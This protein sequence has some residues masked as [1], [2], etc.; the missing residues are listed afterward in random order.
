MTASRSA[1]TAGRR[2]RLEPTCLLYAGAQST[3][4]SAAGYRSRAPRAEPSEPGPQAAAAP[5]P[6][7]GKEPHGGIACSGPQGQ[8]GAPGAGPGGEGREGGANAREGGA[9]RRAGRDRGT[10][11]RSPA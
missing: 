8:G 11:N 4:S 10:E 2:E 5:P 7:G 1:G 3:D 6:F 9:R